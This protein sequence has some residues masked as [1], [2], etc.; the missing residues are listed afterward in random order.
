MLAAGRKPAGRVKGTMLLCVVAMAPLRWTIPEMVRTAAPEVPKGALVQAFWSVSEVKALADGANE[1]P[2]SEV[3]R[4][5]ERGV[6]TEG[7]VVTRPGGWK[8]RSPV[9]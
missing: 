7:W 3:K 9:E 4:S 1:A 5:E 8:H 2:S 6:G